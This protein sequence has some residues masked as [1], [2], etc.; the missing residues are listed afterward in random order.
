MASAQSDDPVELLQ[1]RALADTV[2]PEHPHDLAAADLQRDTVEDVALAVIRMDGLDL[3]ERGHRSAIPRPICF[4]AA[5]PT[6][7]AFP[8]KAGIHGSADRAT[9][10]W[11]P[12]FAGNAT[13]NRI[14]S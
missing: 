5:A 10:R 9:D 14:M 4:A 13:V 8:A 6:S 7:I 1:C 11:V 12:A 2:A 3:K